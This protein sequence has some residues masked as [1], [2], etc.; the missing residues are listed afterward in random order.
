[1]PEISLYLL[2][3]RILLACLVAVAEKP[4]GLIAYEYVFILV[5]HIK[6][7]AQALEKIFFLAC[8]EKF[9]AYKKLERIAFLEDIRYLGAL[10][11]TLYFLCPNEFIHH[12][13]RHIRK[14]LCYEFVK[15]LSCVVFIYRDNLHISLTRLC[16]SACRF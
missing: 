1:M 6:A 14:S 10:S 2:D 8:H 9:L 13:F 12:G 7:R 16:I 5:C 4:D 15:A 3:K 11:V